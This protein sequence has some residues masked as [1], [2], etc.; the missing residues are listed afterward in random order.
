[1][2]VEGILTTLDLQGG[3]HITPLGPEWTESDPD[4]VTLKPFQTSQ[5]YTN[6]SRVGRAVFHLTDDAYLLAASLCGMA[7]DWPV[8]RA[9]DGQGWILEG[10]CGAWELEV[11]SVDDSQ[12]RARFVSKIIRRHRYRDFGGWNRAQFAVLE[13][14]ILLSRLSMLGSE[15]VEA[16]LDRL[17]VLV[18]KTAG[19]RETK[20][21]KLIRQT[22]RDR[23]QTR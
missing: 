6:L 21:W 13:A 8:R 22:T 1:M 19:P 12:E 15:R 17:E 2:I 20:A 18:G 4:R 10:V 23:G 16:E 7:G 14:A 5:T 3:P 9:E 11:E